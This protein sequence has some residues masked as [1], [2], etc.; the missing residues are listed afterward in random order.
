MRKILSLVILI[1]GVTTSVRADRPLLI[2]SLQHDKDIGSLH[3][4]STIEWNRDD[5]NDEKR[6][7]LA[8]KNI[9]YRKS[10]GNKVVQQYALG[11]KNI[12]VRMVFPKQESGR[13]L[14]ECTRVELSLFEGD[15]LLFSSKN[16]G[17]HSEGY[18]KIPRSGIK[19]RPQILNL[20]QSHLKITGVFSNPVYNEGSVIEKDLTFKWST[21]DITVD[22][23]FMNDL[24][25]REVNNI[26]PNKLDAG[27]GK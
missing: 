9:F 15:R 8:K 18:T 13:R 6:E 3:I 22:D 11:G 20:D 12:R 2:I 10:E 25:S 14:N 5:L 7:A 27:D 19:F 26:S 4:M 17:Q 23:N 1:V 16:F 21:A 24:V